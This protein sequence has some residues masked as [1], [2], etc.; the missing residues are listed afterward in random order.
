MDL[1]VTV[2]NILLYGRNSVINW[3]LKETHSY[4]SANAHMQF[5]SELKTKKNFLSY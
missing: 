3:Y 4:R 5:Y 1:C 2:N